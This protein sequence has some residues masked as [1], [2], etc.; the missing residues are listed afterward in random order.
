MLSGEVLFI[1]TPSNA[2]PTGQVCNSTSSREISQAFSIPSFTR[3]VLFTIIPAKSVVEAQTSTSV[4]RRLQSGNSSS[5]VAGLPSPFTK[6]PTWSVPPGH[7]SIPA[8][9]VPAGPR[10][11]VSPLS[12]LGPSGPVA[13][14]A[15]VSPLGP[16]GPVGPGSPPD[17]PGGPCGPAG[18]GGP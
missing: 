9:P 8:G 5:V 17:G 12:P 11:P 14:V 13:P 1:A 16:S 4:S 2:V 10:A 15:P 3:S 18:P 6:C 7:V